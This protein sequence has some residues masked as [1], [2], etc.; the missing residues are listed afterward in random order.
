TD[1]LVEWCNT[2]PTECLRLFADSSQTAREEGRPKE[3]N[4][5]SK[6]AIYIALAQAIF[7]YD[8]S[9][10]FHNMCQQDPAQFISAIE[11]YIKYCSE[12][13]V[14]TGTG[15]GQTYE[16][17]VSNNS[18]KN[19]IAEINAQFPWF[20]DLHGRWKNNPAY[21]IIY[22]TADPTQDFGGQAVVLFQI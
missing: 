6:K 3:T 22:G 13:A 16:D 9:A 8:E 4:N 1:C 2:N 10:D 5:Q 18:A 11:Q 19:L 20:N 12:L 14:I 21:N 15:A 7:L 17:L